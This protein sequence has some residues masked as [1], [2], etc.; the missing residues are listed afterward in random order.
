MVKIS[1]IRY[2][3]KFKYNKI[4]KCTIAI[5]SRFVLFSLRDKQLMVMG[6]ANNLNVVVVCC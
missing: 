6:D 4:V 3:N 1:I 5:F 2:E